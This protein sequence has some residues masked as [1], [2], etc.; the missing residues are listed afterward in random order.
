MLNEKL[1][2]FE[3]YTEPDTFEPEKFTELQRLC[4]EVAPNIINILMT[5]K[6]EVPLPLYAQSP[7]HRCATSSFNYVTAPPSTGSNDEGLKRPMPR[8][9]PD[10]DFVDVISHQILESAQDE[11]PRI[12]PK[13]RSRKL[14]LE[15]PNQPPSEAVHIE[16]RRESSPPPVAL[17]QPG[18][19]DFPNPP[20]RLSPRSTMLLASS[21]CYL[22]RGVTQSE[23]CYS[24]NPVCPPIPEEQVEAEVEMKDTSAPATTAT[25]TPPAS[26]HETKSSQS[27]SLSSL[28]SWA[29][30]SS[31]ES[32]SSSV[33]S[34][35]SI[36]TKQDHPSIPAPAHH[37]NCYTSSS[38]N[39]RDNN[40]ISRNDAAARILASEANPTNSART[41]CSPTKTNCALSRSTPDLLP[42]CSPKKEGARV[43]H[44]N[45]LIS[46]KTDFTA[47]SHGSDETTSC[48]EPRP[49]PSPSSPSSSSSSS[50]QYHESCHRL[51]KDEFCGKEVLEA[52]E[53]LI[54]RI[55]GQVPRRRRRWKR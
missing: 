40:S 45:D 3:D 39:I 43:V 11:A 19:S 49:E 50:P 27:G 38:E 14:G 30:R 18:P 36:T 20:N 1:W 23:S 31:I 7:P 24:F 25:P 4:R 17:P 16:T 2:D 46:I 47:S 41:S 52:R 10:N 37:L 54:A 33:Y 51:D 29:Q 53:K 6:V 9:L 26:S 44:E 55:K 12:P 32:V 35:E 5:M 34:T 42:P 13:S 8:R 28:Q 15:P 48:A 22:E 21:P